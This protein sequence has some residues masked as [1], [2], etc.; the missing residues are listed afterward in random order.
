MAEA[1]AAEDAGRSAV[2]ALAA[3]ARVLPAEQPPA[4]RCFPVE[5]RP[6]SEY[7]EAALKVRLGL[8]AAILAAASPAHRVCLRAPLP[9]ASVPSPDATQ[10]AAFV[11]AR[12]YDPA[13]LGRSNAATNLPDLACPPALPAP[14]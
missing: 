1:I 10:V 7:L 12:L 9:L 11:R 6:P 2:A 13:E 3:A 5:G 4:Q 14:A 8:A